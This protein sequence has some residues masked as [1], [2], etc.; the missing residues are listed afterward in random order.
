MITRW[1]LDT[2]SI[3][4]TGKILTDLCSTHTCFT[5][6]F[7]LVEMLNGLR[8]DNSEFDRRA[9]GIRN[10]IA[11]T[12]Q[13]EWIL[14]EDKFALGFDALET[15]EHRIES[16]QKLIDALIKS[17]NLNA[18][19]ARLR[20]LNL[21]FGADYFE[22]LDAQ[23]GPGYIEGAVRGN[24][25]V[26]DSF[27]REKNNPASLIPAHIR[28]GSYRDNLD[29]LLAMPNLNRGMTILAFAKHLAIGTFDGSPKE[30]DVERIF[31]SYNGKTEIFVRAYTHRST[32]EM[33]DMSQPGKNEAADLAH[34]LY[35]RPGDG[36]I[37]EDKKMRAAA[38]AVGV[39]VVSA[40]ELLNNGEEAAIS[41]LRSIREREQAKLFGGNYSIPARRR[42]S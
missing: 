13:I 2:S 41:A 42:N 9:G 30:A 19:E 4:T 15:E 18:F 36:L 6:A 14:Y 39:P 22:R 25:N 8:K 26:R 23:L 10:L 16:L 31:K 7:T 28:A 21:P 35:L 20:D 3:R 34:F 29:Y 5:S 27:E 24:P 17:E 37:T 12:A 33:R 1:Y 40:I 38:D 32:L 11:S